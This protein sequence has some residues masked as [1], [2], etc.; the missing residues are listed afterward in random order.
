MKVSR[1]V[2]PRLG[3]PYFCVGKDG[4]IDVISLRHIELKDDN[5][6]KSPVN[7]G[8]SEDHFPVKDFAAA[9]AKAVANAKAM[10]ERED[11][12]VREAKA[13]RTRVITL[14]NYPQDSI[15]ED[16]LAAIARCQPVEHLDLGTMVYYVEKHRT[17]AIWYGPITGMSKYHHQDNFSYEMM[18]LRKIDPPR[19]FEKLVDATRLIQSELQ[20]HLS[21]RPSKVKTI[22]PPSRAEAMKHNQGD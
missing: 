11:I 13:A 14:E 17:H 19:C 10:S 22:T 8:L 4:K 18:S 5:N 2:L 21:L 12:L 7:L 16:F 20:P 1:K 3:T 6:L 15:P 9:L